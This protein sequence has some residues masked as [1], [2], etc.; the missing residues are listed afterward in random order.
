MSQSRQADQV[1]INLFFGADPSEPREDLALVALATIQAMDAQ[2]IAIE[3][4]EAFLAGGLLANMR[5]VEG[6]K[7]GASAQA[8]ARL[9]SLVEVLVSRYRWPKKAAEA[10]VLRGQTPRLR[11]YERDVLRTFSDAM[12]SG[13]P[14]TSPMTDEIVLRVRPQATKEEVAEAYDEVRRQ[15]YYKTGK[16]K[17]PIGLPRTRDL[18]VLGYRIWRGDFESWRAAFASYAAENPAD[19]STFC[20]PGTDTVDMSLFR[21][22]TRTAYKTVTGCTLDF[23]PGVVTKSSREEVTSNDETIER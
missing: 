16:R 2:A 10:F 17:R 6:W 8:L 1:D 19:A 3:Y 22:T 15:M 12:P 4:R 23:R 9:A 21:R 20:A 13:N 11:L 18:A 14:A 5:A 7:E